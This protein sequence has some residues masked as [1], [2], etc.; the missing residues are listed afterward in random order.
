MWKELDENTLEKLLF[1][2]NNVIARLDG[3]EKASPDHILKVAEGFDSEITKELTTFIS[4]V[5]K[6]SEVL[7][8]MGSPRPSNEV[9]EEFEKWKK[10]ILDHIK[11]QKHPDNLPE[12][13][14]GQREFGCVYIP[15]KLLKRLYCL[16]ETVLEFLENKSEETGRRAEDQIMEIMVESS[17]WVKYTKRKWGVMSAAEL[18]VISPLTKEQVDNA[19]PDVETDPPF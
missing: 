9:I 5:Y 8:E 7:L 19:K 12:L 17:E 6:I 1:V 2:I 10:R 15:T 18:A 3:T 4:R 13:L 16:G 14:Y 11:V